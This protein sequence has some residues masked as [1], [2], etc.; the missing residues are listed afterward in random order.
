VC[1][2]LPS[3]RTVFDV[4]DFSLVLETLTEALEEDPDRKCFR[5]VGGVLAERT[6]KDVVPALQINRDNVRSRVTIFTPLVLTSRAD[7]EGDL[8]PHGA[9]QD[10]GGCVRVFQE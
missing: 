3:L 2:V 7:Q 8:W 5:L 1:Y 10:E 9:V 4:P 6:V